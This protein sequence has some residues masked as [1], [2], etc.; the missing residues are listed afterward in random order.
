[1]KY[2]VEINADSA[3]GSELIKYIEHLHADERDVHILNEPPL[4]DEE[5][6]LPPT[7]KVSLATLEAWLKPEDDEESM[8]GDE[9]MALIKKDLEKDR[10][11]RNGST[12]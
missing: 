1:M 11:N 12:V 4:T 9:L 7:R 3:K 10:A 2:L 6:A 5:M 8:T